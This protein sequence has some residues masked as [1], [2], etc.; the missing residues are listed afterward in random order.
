[1]DSGLS[2]HVF[3]NGLKLV[4]KQSFG[5]ATSHLGF[6]IN[7]GSRDDGKHPGIAHFFEHMLFRGTHK[8]SS[9]QIINRIEWVGGELNA[10][11]AKDITVV[12]ANVLSDYF[13]RSVD[14]LSDIVFN[15][16]FTETALNKERNIIREEINLYLDTPDE[17]LY[18]EFLNHLYASHPMGYNILGTEE[19]I[20]NIGIKEL[21]TFYNT[22]Y[23]PQNMVLS[24]ISDLPYAKVL[25]HCQ[26][27]ESIQ[28]SNLNPKPNVQ[29][30]KKSRHFIQSLE[31]DFNLAYVCLGKDAYSYNDPKKYNLMLLNNILGGPGMNSKLNM[32][33][34]EK[35]GLTYQI[36]SSYTSYDNTG[37]FYINFATE[38]HQLDLTI[39]LI[40]K[41]VNKLCKAPLKESELKK[42]KQ[43]FKN[44][45]RMAEEN[46]NALMVYNGKQMLLHNTVQPLNTYL[47]LIDSVHAEDLQRTAIEIIQYDQ[48]SLLKIVPV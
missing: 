19:T 40:E 10:F 41:E 27:L 30:L 14:L 5:T 18:D 38:L 4:Y 42:S 32:T 25:E 23:Q 29:G 17:Y 2:S 8:R 26:I 39:A 6:V 46:K 35:K 9:S 28:Q 16:K 12:Y 33:I 37:V 34:R 7:A 43:Q 11:T 36:D 24:V 22:Y 3:S 47:N 31:K 15:S 44:Q 13:K 21:N 20:A 45:L 1:M 48:L